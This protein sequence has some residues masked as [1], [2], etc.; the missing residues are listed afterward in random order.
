LVQPRAEE[1]K[2][3]PLWRLQLLTGRGEAA[4][5][6][7]TATGPRE[8][9]GAVSGEGQLG[10]RDRGCTTG[11]WAWNGLPRAVGTAPSAGVQ[12]EFGQYSQT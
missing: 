2:G 9:H 7:V 10:V 3:E 1:L 11:R 6:S 4:L 5:L 12:A 8:R